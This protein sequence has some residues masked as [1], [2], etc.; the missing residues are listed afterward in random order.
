MPFVARMGNAGVEKRLSAQSRA[1]CAGSSVATGG[2]KRGGIAVVSEGAGTTDG[3]A[4]RNGG[5]GM[6]GR[7]AM[8][9]L[10]ALSLFAFQ[11]KDTV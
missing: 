3:A 11:L 5:R 1:A 7:L 8:T 2:E 10:A 6:T 4:T 9:L